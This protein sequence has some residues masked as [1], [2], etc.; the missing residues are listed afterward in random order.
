MEPWA[1]ISVAA[2]AFQTARF[3]L[4]KRLS[5][6]PL[7]AGGATLAR[8]WYAAP[9]AAIFVSL[10]LTCRDQPAPAIAPS[11]WPYAVAGGASQILATWCVVALFAQ[12]NFAVGITFKK[13]EVVQTALV[14]FVLL[15]DQI[16]P[17]GIAAILVGLIGVLALSEAPIPGGRVWAGLR[18]RATVLGIVS[19]ALFA[20]SAVGYRGATLA[21]D[22]SDPLVRAGTALAI[23]TVMQVFALSAWLA[24]R[25]PG[26]V[27]RVAAA[28]RTA[29]WI[30]LSGLAGSLCWFTAFT[31]QNAA[32]VF[33]VGQIEVI[34][35][36]L[37]ATL[38]FGERISRRELA[39][40]T[41][42]TLSVI[43][44]VIVR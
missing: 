42:I 23:I 38:V 13:T 29:L 39:G 41:L 6:G 19:G 44:V 14:G 21:V 28:W 5:M 36:I 8:F 37:T 31:L 24:L 33:A 20:I 7:S 32:M 4:Q 25:E 30:G 17:P 26:E 10:Y 35:S 34:F 43:A 9:F 18:S 15:G 11:F 12:R 3:L 1:I 16:S 22:S 40:M 2:A 27:A